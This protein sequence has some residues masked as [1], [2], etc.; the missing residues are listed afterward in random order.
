[1]ELTRAVAAAVAVG[2]ACTYDRRVGRRAAQSL[3][4]IAVPAG[5]RTRIDTLACQSPVTWWAALASVEVA[6]DGKVEWGR[7]GRDDS[8]GCKNRCK[9][10]VEQHL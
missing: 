6:L 5:I 2:C 9:D 7:V 4:L 8:K 1:M 10:R 3:C